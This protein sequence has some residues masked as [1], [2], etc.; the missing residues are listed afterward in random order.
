M[1]Y[2]FHIRNNAT[3]EV[4]VYDEQYEWVNHWNNGEESMLFQWFEHNYSCDC[5]REL[6]WHRAHGNAE[7]DEDNACGDERFDVVRIVREN[8]TDVDLEGKR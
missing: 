8:G 5:N 3:G 1:K 4:R 6:F 7:W 2:L